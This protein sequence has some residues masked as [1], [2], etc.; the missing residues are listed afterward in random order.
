MDDDRSLHPGMDHAH[1]VVGSRCRAGEPDPPTRTDGHRRDVES[2]YHRAIRDDPR[3]GDRRGRGDRGNA[4]PTGELE[5]V[6]RSP[7]ARKVERTHRRNDGWYCG[8]VCATRPFTKGARHGAEV[9]GE[10]DGVG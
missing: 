6:D 10:G 1:V 2:E 4:V 7:V 8:Y 9:F 5:L 3:I